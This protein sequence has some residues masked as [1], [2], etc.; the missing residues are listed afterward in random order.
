VKQEEGSLSVAR[1]KAQ[2]RNVGSFS[3]RIQAQALILSQTQA[4][5]EAYGVV[6]AAKAQAERTKIEAEA[7][8][9]ATRLMAEAEA[10]AV[11][12]KAEADAKVI[13]QFAR[14]MELRRVEVQRVGAFGNK[15]VFV[16]SDGPG[17]VMGS[18]M[19]MGLAAGM[20]ANKK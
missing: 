1:I 19:A 16:P 9:E 20:G 17:A 3:L 14:E 10:E 13:D 12:I 6:A 7:Q 11:R 2:A 8:A 18:T 5:S 15:T 4:D